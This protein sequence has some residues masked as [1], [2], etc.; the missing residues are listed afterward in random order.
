MPPAA[1]P[2]PV[3]GRLRPDEQATV[4]HDLLRQ[5]PALCDDAEQAATALL[6]SVSA[7][8][9]A[10]RVTVRLSELG[11]DELAARAG[12]VPGGYVEPAEAAYELVLEGLAPIEAD[13]YRCIA[14]DLHL[15]A[16]QTLLG[17]LV[18]LH[19]CRSPREGTVLAHAGAEV[20]GDH[21]AWILAQAGR[22]GLELDPGELEDLCP[23]WQLTATG[24]CTT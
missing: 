6:R 23:G 15:P 11:L 17:L 19:R 18:G 10:T 22:A 20:P 5:H 8:E 7:D 2:I 1:T 14:L 16:R 24:L 12:R 21:A 9:V 4:L 3:L 13:L